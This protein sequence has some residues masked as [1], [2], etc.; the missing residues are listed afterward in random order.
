MGPTEFS[1]CIRFSDL[2]RNPYILELYRGMS[3][4]LTDS[5]WWIGDENGVRISLDDDNRTVYCEN[6]DREKKQE[7]LCQEVFESLERNIDTTDGYIL[8][9]C[10]GFLQGVAGC[11]YRNRFLGGIGICHVQKVQRSLLEQVLRILQGYLALLAGSLEDHDDLE[12]VHS[13]WSQTITLIDLT[14]LLPRLMIEMCTAIGLPGGVIFLINE[15]GEFFPAYS[16]GYPPD[17]LKRRTLEVSRFEYGESLLPSSIMAYK[18]GEED[19]LRQWLESEM[20]RLH[21]PLMDRPPDCIGVPFFRNENLIGLF[22]SLSP[23]IRPFSETKQSLIR[24]LATSAAAALDNA[25]TVQRM[26]KR[27]KALATIH[28]IHRLICSS[29]TT[30]DLLPRIGH[31]IRQ[32][33]KVEKCSIMLLDPVTHRLLPSVT[34]GLETGEVGQQPLELGEG[35]PGWV[36]ENLNPI[37]YHPGGSPPPWKSIGETY[38]SESYLGVALF[39]NDVEGV[40]TVSGKEDDFNPGD[41]EILLTFAEQAIIAIKNARMHEGERTITVNALRSIA[42]LIETRNPEISGVAA[43]TCEW[44]QRITKVCNLSTREYQNITYA[45]LLHDIGMLRAY[46]SDYSL[47]EMR[48]KGP[49]TGLHFVQ[50]LGLPKEVGEI[51]YHVNEAWNGQ[52]YPEGL[53]G[54]EIP[55]GS[56]IIAV[57]NAYATLLHRRTEDLQQTSE[58]ALQIIKKLSRRSYDPEIVNAL[59]KAIQNPTE[60]PAE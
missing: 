2:A 11:W 35:L 7:T 15:D 59:E 24:L 31:L 36:A 4:L 12:L 57:A 43:H 26:E 51:V 17:L 6:A 29:I 1:S 19:P 34:M 52:G 45:A 9:C 53:K 55:L 48:M 3:S 18:M 13:V 25:L 27:R 38:P 30:D 44:S 46:D 16:S 42:N 33:L 10:D 14:E 37:L 47:D 22:V 56:R 54:E 21:H 58:K 50:S 40:I 8:S 60:Y 32:L 23:S 5:R 49:E 39:D 41:R 20:R 28:V